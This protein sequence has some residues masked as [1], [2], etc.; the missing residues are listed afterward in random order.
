MLSERELYRRL[1]EFRYNTGTEYKI[2]PNVISYVSDLIKNII[3]PYKLFP[4]RCTDSVDDGICLVYNNGDLK[5]Y[6]E[7]YN[8]GDMGYIVED[9]KK[10]KS[11]VNE[12]LRTEEDIK[13]VLINFLN[14]D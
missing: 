2:D 6:M 12:D 3:V 7:F 5:L 13:N 10:R 1:N 8:D 11:L 9:Y 14:N 4:D